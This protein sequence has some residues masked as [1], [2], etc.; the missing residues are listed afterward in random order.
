MG[1]H[2][3]YYFTP[4]Q[5]DIEAALHAL[6]EEEFRAG[7]YNDAMLEADSP[8]HMARF[9]FPPDA[10][11]PAPGPIHPD[12]Q[13]MMQDMTEEGTGSIL[14]IMWVSPTPEPCAAAPMAEEDLRLIF[15]TTQPT[16]ADV[17]RMV[18]PPDQD[19]WRRTGAVFDRI[20]RGEARYF[21]VYDGGS[22]REIFFMGYSFD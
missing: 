11:S 8:Q 19:T 7:R 13:A 6:R 10:N 4:Y 3:Y 1:S 20:R 14:D 21:A 17:E 15:G 18:I 12:I 9:K 5:E 16:R 2:L 22:P